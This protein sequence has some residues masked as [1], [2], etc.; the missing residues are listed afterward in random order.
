MRQGWNSGG[1]VRGVEGWREEGA[2]LG[3]DDELS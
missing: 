1:D 3:G 2:C